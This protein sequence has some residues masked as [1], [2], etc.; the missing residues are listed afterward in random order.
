MHLPKR[1]ACATLAAAL[2]AA[3]SAPAAGQSDETPSSG[4]FK[5]AQELFDL[6]TSSNETDVEA[7]DWFIM[8]A[9]DMMKL[10]G[11]TGMG[12]DRICIPLET[13]EL[14][15]RNTVLAYWRADSG[16]LRYSAVSTVYNAL[17]AAYPC[18]G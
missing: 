5:T 8:A 11:D 4:V 7:C 15:V 10:Y 2:I 12:G 14:E 1:A 17:I 9:H 16:S 18:A 13:P 3:T 6:C